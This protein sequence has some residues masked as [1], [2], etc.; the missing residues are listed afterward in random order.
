M[1]STAAVGEKR[2]APGATDTTDVDKFAWLEHT[3]K[4]NK[5]L[6]HGHAAPGNLLREERT[7]MR[8]VQQIEEI[9]HNEQVVKVHGFV[10]G[11]RLEHTEVRIGG[12][13]PANKNVSEATIEKLA[14][15]IL[16]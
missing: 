13:H 15:K 5:K 2:C 11:T 10:I 4:R 16:R 9:E 6:R 7:M 8:V 1:S 12:H 3:Q 14:N